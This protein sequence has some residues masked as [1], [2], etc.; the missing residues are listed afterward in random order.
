VAVATA[1]L[2]P[3]KSIPSTKSRVALTALASV[4]KD[5]ILS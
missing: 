5:K 3:P 2:V 4:T 1:I